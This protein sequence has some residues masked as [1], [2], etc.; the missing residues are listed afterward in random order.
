[1]E[2]VPNEQIEGA[3]NIC[4]IPT[5][6]TTLERQDIVVAF[7]VVTLARGQMLYSFLLSSQKIELQSSSSAIR[8]ELDFHTETFHSRPNP[9]ESDSPVETSG[10]IQ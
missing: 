3:V 1:M 8:E 6:S 10:K 5:A 7:E 4:C 9:D 2:T